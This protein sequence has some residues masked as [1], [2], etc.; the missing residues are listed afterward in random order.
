MLNL[1][2]FDN[3]DEL[4]VHVGF[5]ESSG[6]PWRAGAGRTTLPPP[7]V[8]VMQC[9]MRRR[10]STSTRPDEHCHLRLLHRPA[11]LR[12]PP[13]IGGLVLGK[14]ISTITIVLAPNTLHNLSL[15]Q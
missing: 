11:I 8:D 12:R 13:N 4:V 14:L 15:M 3:D 5:S 2:Q 10:S 1:L 9:S 7:A 6:V